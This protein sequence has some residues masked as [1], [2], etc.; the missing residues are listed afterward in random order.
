MLRWA[1]RVSFAGEA[2]MVAAKVAGAEFAL[3]IRS[4]VMGCI[5]L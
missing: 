2:F 3:N 4:H 5:I 1:F